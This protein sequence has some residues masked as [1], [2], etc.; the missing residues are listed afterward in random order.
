MSGAP[1]VWACVY[2][3]APAIHDP[4]V[5]TSSKRVV[6]GEGRWH[7][8]LR[9]TSTGCGAPLIATKYGVQPRAGAYLIVSSGVTS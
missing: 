5:T 4:Y 7:V 3:G 6:A 2:D 1:K 9:C 8:L